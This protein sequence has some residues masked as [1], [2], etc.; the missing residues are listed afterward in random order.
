[1]NLMSRVLIRTFF[2]FALLPFLTFSQ[3]RTEIDFR[4]NYFF[5]DQDLAKLTNSYLLSNSL[6]ARPD[7]ISALICRLYYDNGFFGCIVSSE[8][9]VPADSLLISF[10]ADITEGERYKIGQI[11]VSGFDTTSVFENQKFTNSLSGLA[12]N[13]AAVASSIAD[14]LNYFENNGYPFAKI[15]VNSV[16]KDSSEFSVTLNL[17]IEAGKM[18]S[19]DEISIKGNTN[20]SE[21]VILR[22]IDLRPGDRFSEEKIARIPAQLNRLKFFEPVQLPDYYIDSKGR[23]VLEITIKERKVNNFDGIVGYIP[24]GTSEKTGYFTGLVTISLKNLF[25]TGRSS[26][27]RWQKIDRLSS[28]LEFSYFEPRILGYRLNIGG[29]YFQKKQDSVY[30][31]QRVEGMVEFPATSEIF[32]SLSFLRE[33]I[34]PTILTVPAFTVYNSAQNSISAGIRIDTRDDP[35]SPVSGVYF[36]NSFGNTEKSLRGPAEYIAAGQQT[37][38]SIKKITLSLDLFFSP[39]LRQVIMF[40]INGKNISGGMLEV[41][42]LYK[43]GG[44]RSL[45]GYRENQFFGSTIGW[46]NLEYRLLLSRRS[47][48]F[49]FFDSGYYKR[50]KNEKLKISGNEETKSGYGLGMNLETGVGVLNVSYALAKGETFSQGKI[51]FGIINDF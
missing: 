3:T 26:S 2:L 31:Q 7:S 8:K 40:G 45:R 22:E 24:P 19:I 44:T 50:D 13:S 10:S 30:V 38:Y 15:K 28:E 16:V 36:F 11:Y 1:M 14:Y 12:Y 21:N 39:F 6:N 25:G 49:V 46:T 20:T 9:T 29:S 48:G 43:L 35:F 34:I 41:S 27:L 18:Y 42:D 47:Y 5:D 32:F 51:H 33:T 37:K 23:G 17:K 4:G